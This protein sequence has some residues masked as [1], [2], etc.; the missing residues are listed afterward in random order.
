MGNYKI[1]NKKNIVRVERKGFKKIPINEVELKTFAEKLIPGLF[2]PS[3]EGKMNLVYTAP[4]SIPLQKYMKK[5]FTVHKF[6]SVIAQTIEMT[7]KIEMYKLHISNLVL[8]TG[9]IHVKETTG[10]VFFL[11]EPILSRENGIG[12]YAFFADYLRD[13]KTTDDM[14]LKECGAFMQFV[15]DVNNCGI[16]AIEQFV[17]QRYPQIYQQIPRAE[18]GKSGFLA[19]NMLA[20]KQHYHPSM[21][22]GY[23]ES[24]TTLLCEEGTTLLCEEGTTLL[25]MNQ[26][27]AGVMR[28]KNGMRTA[29][30]GNMLTIGKSLENHCAITDNKAVSRK[31]A[32][33][34]CE[35]NM[36]TIC[37]VGST[38]HTYLNG[39]ELNVNRAYPLK[40]GDAILIA[41]EEFTFYVL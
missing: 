1:S 18:L 34:H 24:G 31:H 20:N 25:G 14:L 39:M 12:V 32:V 7:K 5:N 37:D 6:Y 11:Y 23:E 16:E 9:V 8:H 26:I 4:Q 35:N 29:I 2:Q 3:V 38:N 40:D 22:M 41:D 10:E 27:N 15:S 21:Q 30:E 33:I 17:M 28:K 13:I 19:S 36:F